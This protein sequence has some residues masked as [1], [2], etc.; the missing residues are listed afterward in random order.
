MLQ[1]CIFLFVKSSDYFKFNKKITFYQ[2]IQN[3]LGKLKIFLKKNTLK[4]EICLNFLIVFKE[5]LG[6]SPEIP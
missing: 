1:K 2:D 5:F 3:Y 6:N 4:F